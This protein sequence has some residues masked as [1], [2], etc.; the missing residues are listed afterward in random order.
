MIN[1]RAC[2]LRHVWG[3]MPAFLPCL[4]AHLLNVQIKVFKKYSLE[5]ERMDREEITTR[6]INALR[7]AFVPVGESDDALL[8][9]Q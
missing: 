4:R 6:E 7:L 3:I 5:H 8:P 1:D 2:H 9:V